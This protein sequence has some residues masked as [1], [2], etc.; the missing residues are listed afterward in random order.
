MPEGPS[1]HPGDREAAVEV[2]SVKRRIFADLDQ[3]APQHAILATNS[4]AIVSSLIADAT[5]QPVSASRPR[6]LWVDIR[7]RST[8]CR[9]MGR[10]IVPLSAAITPWTSAR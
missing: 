3:M 2:L 10:R 7:F 1:L 4:S 5:R 9:P 8:G 6:R